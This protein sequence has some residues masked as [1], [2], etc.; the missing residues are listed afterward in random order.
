MY[1]S[2]QVFSAQEGLQL[3][4]QSKMVKGAPGHSCH[5]LIQQKALVQKYP[6]SPAPSQGMQPILEDTLNP[7]SVLLLLTSNTSIL[8]GLSFSY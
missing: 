2:G 3:A 5:L 8:S 1:H 6:P 7:M 4:N